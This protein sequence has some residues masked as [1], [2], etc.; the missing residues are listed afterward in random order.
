[1]AKNST[2]YTP[3]NRQENEIFIKSIMDAYTIYCEKEEGEFVKLCLFIS[4]WPDGED[5]PIPI[6]GSEEFGSRYHPSLF[7]L[8][9]MAERMAPQEQRIHFDVLNRYLFYLNFPK[10]LY[11]RKDELP[12]NDSD[13]AE[14]INENIE[15]YQR[16]CNNQRLLDILGQSQANRIRTMLN[17]H[18]HV[19]RSDELSASSKLYEAKSKSLHDMLMLIKDRKRVPQVLSTVLTNGVLYHLDKL[20]SRERS[21]LFLE[22]ENIQLPF[23]VLPRTL[24][25]KKNLGN[26]RKYLVDL[27]SKADQWRLG[28]LKNLCKVSIEFVDQCDILS[29]QEFDGDYVQGE[30]VCSSC[31]MVFAGDTIA[32]IDSTCKFLHEYGPGWIYLPSNLNYIACPFC[33]QRAKGESLAMFHSFDRKQIIYCIPSSWKERKK[34]GIEYFAS[35]FEGIRNRYKERL[36]PEQVSIFNKSGEI[37]AW[38][39]NEFVYAIQTGNIEA[40]GHVENIVGLPDGNALLIDSVKKVAIGIPEEYVRKPE[41]LDETSVL[42]RDAEIKHAMELY[43]SGQLLKSREILETLVQEDPTNRSLNAKLAV[44]LHALGEEEKSNQIF[45]K[46]AENEDLHSEFSKRSS[47]FHKG[48]ELQDSGKYEEA[49]E[50]YDAAM[51][52]DSNYLLALDSKAY[53]LFRLGQYEE[54]IECYDRVIELGPKSVWYDKDALAWTNKGA[55]LSKLRKHEEAIEC[56]DRVI[57]MDSNYFLVWYDYGI[58]IAKLGRYEEAVKLFDKS[59]EIDP[60]HAG[61]WYWRARSKIKMDDLESGLVDLRKAIELNSEFV[62]LAKQEYDFEKIRNDKRFKELIRES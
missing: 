47:Y 29:L 35:F 8:L 59:L 22:S 37:F 1:M 13:L 16:L 34:D 18:D 46:L 10:I 51:T 6:P 31:S 62:E 33:N 49:I 28:L 11:F 54:A 2:I 36:S 53:C 39:W 9:D 56:Y 25:N 50:C 14:E 55:T 32:C 7:S 48:C 43:K 12:E 17:S 60:K 26:L 3:R 27:E 45:E 40:E 38:G 15:F 52:F 57:E 61:S 20:S 4:R 44:I 5:T 19:Q 58:T 41:N 24:D 30:A 23:S 21:R 42:E